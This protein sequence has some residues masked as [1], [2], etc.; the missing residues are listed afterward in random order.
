M[1]INVLLSVKK[2]RFYDFNE[3]RFVVPC[4]KLHQYSFPFHEVLISKTLTQLL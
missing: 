3:V 2:L 4:L 1:K